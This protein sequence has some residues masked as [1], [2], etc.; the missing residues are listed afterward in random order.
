MRFFDKFKKNGKS[1]SSDD[2]NSRQRRVDPNVMRDSGMTL[3]EEAEMAMDIQR[4]G[5]YEAIVAMSKN[6]CPETR[7][8][9]HKVILG[10]TL[11]YP[12]EHHEDG[13]ASSPA[14][15]TPEGD[16]VWPVYTHIE[17]ME[18]DGYAVDGAFIISK[19]DKI[20]QTAEAGGF[21]QVRINPAGPAGGMVVESEIPFLARGRSP[22]GEVRDGNP[23]SMSAGPPENPLPAQLMSTVQQFAKR[24]GLRAL[25]YIDIVVDEKEHYPSVYFDLIDKGENATQLT[26][27]IYS[28]LKPH[29][30]G[31]PYVLVPLTSQEQYDDFVHNGIKIYPN[32]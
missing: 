12:I 21:T 4:P 9:F 30:V 26:E 1:G 29:I 31:T 13:S 7:L 11:W 18:L 6:D 24:E 17:A 20:F 22:Y 8:A 23:K 5:F 27:K 3:A 19:A 25:Y 32:S 2:G 28:E 16:V 15:K 10:G 14:Y